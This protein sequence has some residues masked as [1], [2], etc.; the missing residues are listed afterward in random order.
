[1]FALPL[2][3]VLSEPGRV[4]CIGAKRLFEYVPKEILLRRKFRRLGRRNRT[5]GAL[6]VFT[7]SVC[8]LLRST[9]HRTDFRLRPEQN[10]ALN[11]VV[12]R[13]NQQ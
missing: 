12:E 5:L 3:L 2:W 11:C 1:M 8:V 13:S 6:V 4:P 9:T 10:R 7:Y